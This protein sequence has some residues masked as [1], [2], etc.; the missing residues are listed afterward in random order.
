M[1]L[2]L[3]HDRSNWSSPSFYST[4]FQIFKVFLVY[5]PTFI[6]NREIIFGKKSKN[7]SVYYRQ[8]WQI[9]CCTHPHDSRVTMVGIVIRLQVKQPRNL[10]S[11]HVR[12]ERFLSFP[13]CLDRFWGPPWILSNGYRL[14]LEWLVSQTKVLEKIETCFMFTN[15]FTPKLWRLWDNM[16]KFCRD[17]RPQMTI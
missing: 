13:K 8:T 12:N 3:Y 9:T 11:I 16:E 15:F 17:K 6:T 10:G 4:T 1:L 5:F 2:H 14:F 7:N